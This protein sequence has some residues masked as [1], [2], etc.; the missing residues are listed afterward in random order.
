MLQTLLIPLSVVLLVSTLIPSLR[1]RARHRKLSR[2]PQRLKI[3]YSTPIA[4]LRR[5]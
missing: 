1:D 3:I 5:K 2:G 4:P